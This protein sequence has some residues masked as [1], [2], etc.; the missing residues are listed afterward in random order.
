MH[1]RSE[2]FELR[3]GIVAAARVALCSSSF[4]KV[5]AGRMQLS[6]NVLALDPKRTSSVDNRKI[7]FTV[8]IQWLDHRN[9]GHVIEI[10]GQV[11]LGDSASHGDHES[12]GSA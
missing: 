9:S 4:L 6:A 2:Y 5:H 3:W 12:G 1:A 8:H 10:T 11:V 7:R